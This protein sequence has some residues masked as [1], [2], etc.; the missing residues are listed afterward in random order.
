MKSPAFPTS[1]RGNRLKDPQRVPGPAPL[2][3]ATDWGSRLLNH[4]P[5]S[6]PCDSDTLT[7][8]WLPKE[9]TPIMPWEAVLAREGIWLWLRGT[10][11]RASAMSAALFRMISWE[12][13]R[14]GRVASLFLA[15]CSDVWFFFIA[16]PQ[17]LIRGLSCY[18]PDTLIAHAALPNIVSKTPFSRHLRFCFCFFCFFGAGEMS[19]STRLSGS[20]WCVTSLTWLLWGIPYRA[21]TRSAALFSNTSW[22]GRRRRRKWRGEGEGGSETWHPKQIKRPESTVVCT[23]TNGACR[24]QRELRKCLHI[25]PRHKSRVHLRG[26]PS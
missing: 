11:Y 26:S 1:P 18:M 9:L 12:A 8:S 25:P 7:A 14:K 2:L 17:S 20:C 22:W 4:I 10:L 16:L 19:H 24:G 6:F 13:R 15:S 23:V 21:S 3:R 5:W